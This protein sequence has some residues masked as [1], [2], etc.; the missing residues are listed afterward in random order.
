MIYRR[1]KKEAKRRENNRYIASA[2]N[3]TRAKW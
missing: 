3:K 2:K 1:T